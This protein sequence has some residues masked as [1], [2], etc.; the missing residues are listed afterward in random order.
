M[1]Y[2]GIPTS[3]QFPIGQAT[4]TRTITPNSDAS[5]E[6]AETVVLTL[7][8][9]AAYDLG[10]QIADTVT[11]ADGPPPSTTTTSSTSTSTTSSS[12]TST[13]T[14]TTTSTSTLPAACELLTGEK[15]L[16][17]ANAGSD[18][19]GIGL[20]SADSSLTLGD[21]NGSVDDPVLHGGTL[22]VVSA[23]GDFDD[24]YDFPADRWQYKKK[25]GANLG[26][27]LRRTSPFKSITVQ[28]GKRLNV[29]ANGEG[30]G[31]TLDTNPD[32]VDV[33]LTLG[34]HCYCLRFGG[35][36][37]FKAGKKWLAK[38]APAPTGCPTPVSAA[39]LRR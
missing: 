23:V 38:N 21:G 15:L 24:T 10:S 32:P 20:L 2:Q 31:H 36:V 22:R 1:D 14:S 39:A 37:S 33:V 29:V 7:T 19:R 13:T 30:L 27:K 4:V 6:G 8:D 18:K 35:E 25:E 17:K 5:V 28:P 11:I 3:I 9:G 26:Y 16:L 12:S 34:E